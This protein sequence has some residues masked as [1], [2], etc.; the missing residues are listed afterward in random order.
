[1]RKLA[2]IRQIA[3]IKPH[4]NADALEL[5]IVDGWQCVVKK[6][7][8]RPGDFV[9]Y[10]EVDSV[11]PINPLFEFLRKSCYV[12][13]DWLPAGEGFRLKT[14]KLRGE[15][16]Q[17]LVLPLETVF[18]TATGLPVLGQDVT[19]ILGVVKWDPPM[20]AQLQ[21]LARG[22]FPS[23]IQKTDQERIQNVWEEVKEKYDDVTFE[24]TIKLDGSSCT[25]YHNEGDVGV[26]SR[27]L[28]LNLEGNDNLS[29]IHI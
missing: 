27:N 26:C 4:T 21:G 22:V 12:K 8:V 25:Y 28:N 10:F 5:A 19:E 20:P 24:V 14:I 13:K 29:L 11:L 3:E 7:E 2:S 17:G 1:M 23:F 9:V 18:P 16:S 6:G 15:I